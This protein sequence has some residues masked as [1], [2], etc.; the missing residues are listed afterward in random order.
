[1]TSKPTSIPDEY[2]AAIPMLAVRDAASALAFYQHV[3]DAIEVMRLEDE[4]GLISHSE[5]RIGDAQIMV[6]DPAP[7]E[8]MTPDEIGG[9]PVIIHLF[10]PD[11]V[12]VF[13][14]AENAGA[15][16]LRPLAYSQFTAS[17]IGKF[18]DPFGHVWLLQSHIED[19][20]PAK[21]EQRVTQLVEQAARG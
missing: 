6:A 19:D 16:I 2:R 5:I 20:S 18:R 9:T 7:G 8:N 11:G 3:F 15:T 1:M 4:Q 17:H 10:V 12:T 21:I 14:R 13:Q